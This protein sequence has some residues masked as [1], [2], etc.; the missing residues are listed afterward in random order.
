MTLRRSK[1]QFILL[2]IASTSPHFVYFPLSAQSN[3]KYTLKNCEGYQMGPLLKNLK[4]RGL[5]I[6][7]TD[8]FIA[9]IRRRRFLPITLCNLYKGSIYKNQSNSQKNGAD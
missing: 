1:N 3:H 5:K 8:S 6:S 4:T 7:V 2:R 9:S